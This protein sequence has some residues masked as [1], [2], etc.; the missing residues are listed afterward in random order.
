MMSDKT[1]Q[2]Y[3]LVALLAAAAVL[4]FFIVRPFI[5]PL[6]LGAVFAVV[7]QPAYLHIRRRLRGSPSLASL[8]TVLIFLVLIL[9][10]CIF[11]GSRI[12]AESQ[13]LYVTV[14]SGEWRSGFDTAF[15]QSVPWLQQY[16]PDA[17]ARLAE[18]SASLDEYARAGLAWL[19][20]H[21]GVAFS[22]VSAFLLALFIFFIALYYL[23]KEGES[24]SRFLVRLSPLPDTQDEEIMR[25]LSL[26][27]TSVVR[28]QFLLALIQGLFVGAGLFLFGVPNAIIWALLAMV[29]AIIPPLGTAIVT[30]PAM[31]FLFVTGASGAALGLLIWAGIAGLIDNVLGPRL[32]AQGM[33]QHPLV[34]MLSVL[35]GIAF[36]GP[37][38]IFLG[39]LAVSFFLTL[40][41]LHIES[42]KHGADIA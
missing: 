23:L 4:V 11:F 42:P 40:I 36:F 16:V 14:A 34:M 24:L 10:P 7:L 21:L 22:G 6:A 25:R 13:Q 38:G 27:V 26:A 15:A 19:I 3:F 39:P 29:A 31:L 8:V 9:I 35:G 37:V 28:G 2:Q 41:A 5:A 1:I 33:K 30:I 18:I 17:S 32:M 12:L 20:G